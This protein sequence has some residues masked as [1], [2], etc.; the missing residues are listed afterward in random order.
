MSGWEARWGEGGGKRH[1][2]DAENA[3]RTSCQRAKLPPP[4]DQKKN[5]F[6]RE[7]AKGPEEGEKLNWQKRRR[8]G[9]A[10]ANVRVLFANQEEGFANLRRLAGSSSPRVDTTLI[11][12]T[13]ESV[14]A[15]ASSVGISHLIHARENPRGQGGLEPA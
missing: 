1:P 14:N 4:G 11:T 7:G 9:S 15:A 3:T 2:S 13:N 12:L 10:P 6:K 5:G 8:G